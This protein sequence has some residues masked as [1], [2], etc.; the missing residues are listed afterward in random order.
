MRLNGLEAFTCGE[1][2]GILK[3]LG[4]CMDHRTSFRYQLRVLQF[5]GFVDN[6]EF[7]RG[8][9]GF[10]FKSE[11]CRNLNLTSRAWVEVIRTHA[12]SPDHEVLQVPTP[13]EGL[14][15][16][17]YSNQNLNQTPCEFSVTATPAGEGPPGF[18]MVST[19]V[20]HLPA[21]EYAHFQATDANAISHGVSCFASGTG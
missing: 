9:F 7:T 4:I 3:D 19:C 10:W 6:T 15:R 18:I 14:R 8:W 16:R 2:Q 12:F 20:T 21:V 5:P 1:S 13:G 11:S 17:F